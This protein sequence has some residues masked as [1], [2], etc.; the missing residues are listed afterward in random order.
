MQRFSSGD[1]SAG[2]GVTLYPVVAY[3]IGLAP[4]AGVAII[5]VAPRGAPRLFMLKAKEAGGDL[6][7]F[8]ESLK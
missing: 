7:T 1:G 3:V 4:G 2:H 5:R 6:L 8:Q